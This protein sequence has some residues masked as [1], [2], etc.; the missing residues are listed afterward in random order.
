MYN[1][2]FLLDI[3]DYSISP[4]VF[5][6]IF[7]LLIILMKSLKK[8]DDTNSVIKDENV[9]MVT[10]NIQTPKGD[11][12]ESNNINLVNNSSLDKYSF[13]MQVEDVFTITGRG[14]VVTGRVERGNLKINDEVDILSSAGSRR[15]TVSG[16]EMFRKSLDYA[17]AGDNV[18]ILLSDINRD[19]INRGDSIVKM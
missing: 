10:N 9:N 17:Q 1:Y 18:G 4:L 16:I 7:I 5:V 15:T 13:F 19:E 12:V 11:V 14:T 3:K 2:I 8:K 6:G